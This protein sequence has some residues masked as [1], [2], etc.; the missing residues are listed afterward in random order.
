[1]D[2]SFTR[3]SLS[4]PFVQKYNCYG[5]NSI[6]EEDIHQRSS[7]TSSSSNYSS[8]SHSSGSVLSTKRVPRKPVMNNPLL[9]G[10]REHLKQQQWKVATSSSPSHQRKQRQPAVIVYTNKQPYLTT[11]KHYDN[12][13]TK[14]NSNFHLVPSASHN[15]KSQVGCTDQRH[16][17]KVPQ[18][19]YS[20]ITTIAPQNHSPAI[21]SNS[22]KKL[23]KTRRH[24]QGSFAA[25]P[26][27]YINRDAVLAHPINNENKTLLLPAANPVHRSNSDGSSRHCKDQTKSPNFWYPRA[28]SQTSEQR[29]EPLKRGLSKKL[30]ELLQ[31]QRTLIQEGAS[32]EH[33]V[34]A[35]QE[36]LKRCQ[37]PILEE[38]DNNPFNNL[39]CAKNVVSERK[40]G[41]TAIT[42]LR[43]ID[44]S[45]IDSYASTVQQRGPLLTP[46]ILSQK[47][48]ARPYRK[49]L[50]RLRAIFIWLLQNIRPE[51]H[52]KRYDL[53][54]AHK[55]QQILVSSANHA[56]AQNPLKQKLI[57]RMTNPYHP[58]KETGLSSSVDVNATHQSTL[59]AMDS[60]E[61]EALVSL[62]S[63][64][65]ISSSLE[66]T[67]EEVLE[68]RSCK[69][70]FGMARLFV[71]M[72]KAAGFEDA[73]VIY[74]YLKVPKD[75]VKTALES[76]DF[77]PGNH[78][79]CLVRIEGE[80]RMIDC[81]LASPFYPQNENKLE[82][83]WFLTK[84]I[85]MIMTHIPESQQDQYLNPP[86]S[87]DDFFR[88]PYVRNPFFWYRME[89]IAY[90]VELVKSKDIFY[91][92][93]KL[94]QPPNTAI[95]CYAETEAEDG[96][97]ARGL[98]QCL[99]TENDDRLCKVKAVLPPHQY[100]GWLKIYAG[101]AKQMNASSGHQQE[102]TIQHTH[103]PLAL[104]MYISDR[105]KECNALLEAA[106]PFDF[107]QLYTYPNEFYIQEP[108]CYYL[109]PLQTYHFCVRANVRSME[110]RRATM[111]H[112]KL[113]I[114]SPGG[115]LV[116]LMYYPQDQTYDCT[117]TIT[118]A[119]EWSLICL[120]HHTGGSYTVASWSCKVMKK[121]D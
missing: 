58:F 50:F 14:Q 7:S 53:L 12:M 63:K 79:W 23:R 19:S 102:T 101:P 16:H 77:L 120:Q 27:S 32:K 8:S 17:S 52:Q 87:P 56:S 15:T 72:A 21:L 2:E 62:M 97:I 40:S 78:A 100:S 95:N 113:A 41:T 89:I 104:C 96:T 43:K 30:R 82:P 24:S 20:A 103:Y 70:A 35:F 80:Y 57:Q 33:Y 5:R 119:G 46:A 93:L 68:K 10:T 45:Q 112:H 22:E 39:S 6:E 25:Q 54:L 67:S 111:H 117:V 92:S 51:Y 38:E 84:P 76:K 106:G 83:H 116:K 49:E 85:D 44:F 86:L 121:K 13:A 61:E 28:E 109:Y 118:E 29:L 75:T 36:S 105:S 110:Q 66:E 108:Q 91:V 81:W 107:V 26:S 99:T 18:K 9:L 1:M 48:L 60:L 59:D 71:E 34:E 94:H 73:H 31:P 4:S 3:Y 98:A 114:K 90:H 11:T 88:L 42:Q 37:S 47:F 65:T 115:K 64:S 74:G 69:S 55:Q